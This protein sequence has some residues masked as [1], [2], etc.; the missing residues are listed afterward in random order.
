[1]SYPSPLWWDIIILTVISF[2]GL[3]NSGAPAELK[4]V[5]TEGSESSGRREATGASRERSSRSTS[6]RR[7]IE[8]RSLVQ[9]ATHMTVSGEMGL[10]ARGEAGFS[11]WVPTDLV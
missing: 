4:P 10:E 2:S 8:V 5:K 6:C 7:E 1:M 9:E 11:D 3:V